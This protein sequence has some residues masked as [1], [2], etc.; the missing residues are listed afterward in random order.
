MIQIG[1]TPQETVLVADYNAANKLH[2][3]FVQNPNCV[4]I[5]N[6]LI[7]SNLEVESLKL[8]KERLIELLTGELSRLNMQKCLIRNSLSGV[9]KV[10]PTIPVSFTFN[11]Y[12]NYEVEFFVDTSNKYTVRRYRIGELTV[13]DSVKPESKVMLRDYSNYADCV[14]DLRRQ[15]CQDLGWLGTQ[16]F[17]LPADVHFI[18]AFS[19]EDSCANVYCDVKKRLFYSLNEC[20]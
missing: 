12:G 19:S 16:N 20:E 4:N 14:N 13:P 7:S 5:L 2:L 11:E 3:F 10:S 1:L 9:I 6:S 8:F 15:G 17:I 18:L